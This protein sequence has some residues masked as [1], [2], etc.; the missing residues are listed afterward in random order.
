MRLL[1]WLFCIVWLAHGPSSAQAQ[2]TLKAHF[3][4]LLN[5]AAKLRQRASY[6]SSR[7]RLEQALRLA[8]AGKRFGWM[9]KT[10]NE[11][12][13][14]DIYTGNYTSA[15][16]HI[17]EALS[18]YERMG[19]DD[20]IAECH[21]NMGAIYYDQ[22]DLARA[23]I[24]YG[25]SL[26]IRE[27]GTD[28]KALGIT[29][30]NLGDVNAKLGELES[31]LEFH[32]MSL[33]IWEELESASGK[34]ITLEYI[35]NCM[36]AQGEH[37]AALEVMMKAH[38][39]L[40]ADEANKLSTVVVGT[41]IGDLLNRLGR[42][43]EAIGWCNRAYAAALALDSKREQQKSCHCLYEAHLTSNRPKEA[44]HYYQQYVALRDSLFGQEMTK[45]MTRLEMNYA[46]EK[47]QL[48]D[49]LRFAAEQQLQ[50]E[51]IQRQRIGLVSIGS[52]L[53]LAAALGFAILQGKRKSDSL[54]LNILPRVT[55]A[56]L[57]KTGTA[58]SRHF[59]SVTVLFTDFQG[60]TEMATH[61]DPSALVSDLHQCFSEFDRICERHGIEKIKTIGDA[62]M[63]AGGLPTPNST[64]A[65]DVVSAALDMAEAVEKG[66]ARKMAA[67]LPYFE[68]RIGIHSG[69]VVAGI[70]GV[71]KF[72]YDIWGD[73]VNT[74]SRM[75]SSGE[76]G[77]VNI[78]Q[79]TYELV[80]DDFDCTFR[81]EM[82]VKGK[83]RTGMWFASHKQT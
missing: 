3:D 9:A 56:E 81:G 39:I 45:E 32:R 66:K 70:V 37:D 26:V 74:A 34:A 10:R 38:E 75:E 77:K 24:S 27:Q 58:Q 5:D 1:F 8:D 55:A 28:R 61:M 6:D 80:K 19:M 2:D 72:Q 20:G 35:G 63:A 15:L 33:A 83:G 13:V 16:S 43:Q 18:I 42:G 57:K 17:Q 60:F 22:G 59:E 68:V 48:A 46:F 44:L 71:R 54:L 51:R 76:V 49:S 29:L 41:R 25:K 23:R 65:H 64:H 79:R 12:G 7:T 30:N 36:G 47:K 14:L 73:T 53:L 78:S 67:G 31:A 82:E 50:H 62:Y 21:N 4:H 40:M 52:M 11:L 69:P